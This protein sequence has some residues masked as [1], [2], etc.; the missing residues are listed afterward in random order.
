MLAKNKHGTNLDTGYSTKVTPKTID[1][2]NVSYLDARCDIR[3]SMKLFDSYFIHSHPYYILYITGW[4][5]GRGKGVAI[6]SKPVKAEMFVY[7]MCREVDSGIIN[8]I[9]CLSCIKSMC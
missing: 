4:S 2:M 3:N 1:G 5:K 6:R 7:R 8:I 9:V